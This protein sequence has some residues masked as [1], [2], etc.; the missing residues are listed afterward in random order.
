M[1]PNKIVLLPAVALIV[2]S[3]CV[4]KKKYL[5][6]ESLKLNAEKQVSQLTR[7]NDD[8]QKRIKTMIAD[9]ESIKADMLATNAHKDQLISNLHQEMS[10]I[11]N[12]AAEKNSNMEDKL[13]AYEY[14]KRQLQSKIDG[15]ETNVKSLTEKNQTLVTQLNSTQSNLSTLK[16][17]SNQ[18]DSE[19]TKL[20][21]QLKSNG[22][23][24]SKY[25]I[26]INNLNTDIAALKKA[27]AEKDQ[28]I[29]RL[30]NNVD[31]LKKELQ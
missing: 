6:M 16:F 10:A 26:Q 8:M 29:K 25:Q 9:Y 4:S 23:A 15:F 22:S 11:S 2:L 1:Q 7:Q 18:K 17:D 14:E 30:Q 24:V 28:T 3:G 19:I 27:S 31:L 20:N 5:E 13:Y 21:Q 12:S